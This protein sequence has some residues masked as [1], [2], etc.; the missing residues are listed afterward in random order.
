MG[1][2]ECWPNWVLS[3][4]TAL[5]NELGVQL[6]VCAENYYYNSD[7]DDCFCSSEVAPSQYY[8]LK[9]SSI[10]KKCPKDCKC[11]SSGCVSCEK[12]TER[13]VVYDKSE[14]AYVCGCQAPLIEF[15]NTCICTKDCSC[16]NETT[17]CDQI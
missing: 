17:F 14:E 13:Q 9:I 2:V 8:Y 4:K 10:C 1:C 7:K 3:E 6:C 16:Q 12:T 11:N 15:N 5:E